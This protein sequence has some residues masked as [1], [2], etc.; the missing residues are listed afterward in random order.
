MK[1]LGYIILIIMWTGIV[2]AGTAVY[3]SQAQRTAYESMSV[4]ETKQ[5]INTVL[6][7]REQINQ[8]WVEKFR[9]MEK[10]MKA[11]N[12]II[13]D[14]QAKIQANHAEVRAIQAEQVAVAGVPASISNAELVGHLSKMGVH[15]KQV[16]G[17]K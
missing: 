14:L 9:L 6:A 1:L 8:A 10:A 11:R 17:G 7:N 2:S 5:L 15:V 13:Q 4:Q 16:R 12:A 3:V